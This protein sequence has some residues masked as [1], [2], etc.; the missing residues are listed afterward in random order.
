MISRQKL[1]DAVDLIFVRV[2][3]DGYSR[4]LLK[5]CRTR[6]V[7]RAKRL[8]SRMGPHSEA[9][10]TAFHNRL[11]Y[12]YAKSGKISDAQKLFEKISC[13]DV[14]T[15]NIMLSAYSKSGFVKELQTLFNQ[16]PARDA[17]S[18]NTVI[19]GLV[20]NGGSKNALELFIR[21]QK[22][23]FE[24]DQY[25]YVSV[26]NACSQLLNLKCGQQIHGQLIV[27]N[28]RGN[29]F[30]SNS[31]IDMY[32][33]CGKIDN[34]RWLFDQMVDRNVVSWN[35]MISGYL[36]NKEPEKCLDLFHS[37]Q[38]S[39]VKPDLVTVSSVLG[40]YLQSGLI[41]DATR[42]FK[43]M[44]EKDRVSWTTMIVG[45]AQNGKE[46][47][48]LVLFG[49][50][51]SE[52]VNPDGFTISSVVSA[53]ARLASVDRGKVVHG[54][55]ILIGVEAELQ[56]S[57]ALIDM[58]SKCGEIT[59]ASA[60]FDMMQARNV[61]S[62]NAMIV[63]CAQNG[64]DQEALEHYERMLQENLKPDNVTF[65]GVLSAC[66]HIGLVEHGQRYFRSI[67]K[68]HGI[69]PT[70]DHYVCM[71]NLLGRFGYMKE[72]VDLIKGMPDEPNCLIWS[73]L[74]SVSAI[75]NDIKHAEMAARHLFE[76]DPLNAGPYIMLS[77]MYAASG[78]WDEVASMRTLM[79]DRNIRKFAAYSWIEIDKK[80]HK[81]VSDDR[82]HPKTGQIYEELDRLIQKVQE[83]GFTP[84]TSFVL[85]DVGEAEKFDSI[86]YHSEKLALAFGLISKPQGGTS[87]RI[88]KNIRVCGDC[89]V[90]MKFVCK[91]TKRPI[92]L[93]DSNRF[94]HFVGG[95]CSC[96]DYW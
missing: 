24:R 9:N 51:L 90:F 36:K 71:I 66:S 48:A 47:D 7:D 32:A 72:T 30:V 69:T 57:S 86:C 60:V 23:G 31:L 45:Y 93:R 4:L 67:S 26:L 49:K 61:V 91:I 88:V 92:I 29:L 2:G 41:E 35:S 85:H 11:L 58:Y 59:D 63:G 96:K 89:H 12:L 74:L 76:L 1:H 43:E 84:D 25:T 40:A 70:S 56:V 55:A 27:G 53:C 33:K 54:K 80:V 15:W 50:M 6:S 44:K 68:L 87:I 10:A 94:H 81:F 17:I 42:I 5:R 13:R 19:S 46:E 37:M 95:E 16:M 82:R 8:Q 38:L 64:R 75:N 14:R 83:A 18:Y 62:W 77:N 20:G 34:A 73:T 78:R 21:M 52:N 28:V 65:V 3:D 22:E 39:G 79:K